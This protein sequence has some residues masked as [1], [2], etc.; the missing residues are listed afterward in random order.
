MKVIGFDGR[1]YAW[2]PIGNTNTSRDVSSFHAEA[3]RILKLLF[4]SE[5]I[6]EEVGLPGTQPVLF[7]DFVLPIRNMI[8]E[9]HGSQHYQWNQFFHNTKRD[10]IEGKKRD[11]KKKEWCKIN[12]F[13]FVELPHWENEHEW[14]H[15]IL[16][17]GE[18]ES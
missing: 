16:N 4:P 1:S 7:A 13:F 12:N 14:R 18:T 2:N 6:L 8:I 9:V 5:R 17:F 15:R 11:I 10:F 3:R